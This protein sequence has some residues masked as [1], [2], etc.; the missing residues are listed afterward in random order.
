MGPQLRSADGQSCCGFLQEWTMSPTS[1]FCLCLVPSVILMSRYLIAPHRKGPGMLQKLNVH[2]ELS[3]FY[4]RN[5]SS[6]DALSMV[7][8]QPE[9]GLL[10]FLS[11][12]VA[13]GSA[14]DSTPRFWDLHKGF[15]NIYCCLSVPLSLRGTKVKNAYCASFW[16]HSSETLKLTFTSSAKTDLY[17]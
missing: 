14:L 12:S 15:L 17:V 5:L 6:E 8:C 3:Y 9:E 13:Q 2:F 11:V 4:W 16:H 7:S 1:L 10:Y